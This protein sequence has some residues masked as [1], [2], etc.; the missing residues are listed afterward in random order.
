[1]FY[2][3]QSGA[4]RVAATVSS[5]NEHSATANEVDGFFLKNKQSVLVLIC[6]IED[7]VN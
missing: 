2:L 1:M 6:F 7:A 3:N 4:D 5:I